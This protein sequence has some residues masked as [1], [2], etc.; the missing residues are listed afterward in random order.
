MATAE[1][2]TGDD[3]I[4][5]DGDECDLQAKPGKPDRKLGQTKMFDRPVRGQTIQA[6][7]SDT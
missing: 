3:G 4:D 5:P 1:N 7:R 2:T 6:G